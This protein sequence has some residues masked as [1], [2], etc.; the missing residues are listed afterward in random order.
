MTTREDV[1][2]VVEGY[3]AEHGREAADTILLLGHT[4]DTLPPAQFEYV[5][6][7]SKVS[8]KTARALAHHKAG[9]L[10][11][12]QTLDELAARIW[13][14]RNGQLHAEADPGTEATADD[15]GKPA[16]VDSSKA[17]TLDD[18]AAGA[19]AKRNGK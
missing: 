12:P 1:N 8:P 16:P 17:K 2:A 6:C 15:D 9:D 3:A 4:V 14:K 13:A 18:L 11:P 7:M 19:W 10:A 5:K